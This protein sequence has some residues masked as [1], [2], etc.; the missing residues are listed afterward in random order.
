MGF[1]AFFMCRKY[2]DCFFIVS[3]LSPFSRFQKLH[4]LEVRSEFTA[5]SRLHNAPVCPALSQSIIIP[6][7]SEGGY[8]FGK[9]PFLIV[10]KYSF[11]RFQKL[12]FL[13]W[14]FS[15]TALFIV[16]RKIQH[17]RKWKTSKIGGAFFFKTAEMAESEHLTIK[18]R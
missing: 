6:S 11:Y 12:Q 14:F 15:F 9:C 5:S 1:V 7:A 8:W 17:L 2:R 13:L 18:F 3:L 16:P 10:G 4:F